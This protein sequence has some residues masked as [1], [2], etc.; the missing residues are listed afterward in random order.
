MPSGSSQLPPTMHSISTTRN[1]K[2]G[3]P[4]SQLTKRDRKRH[5][6]SHVALQQSH[7]IPATNA[8]LSCPADC[9][10]PHAIDDGI[11]NCRDQAEQS[12]A[13][14]DVCIDALAIH[15]LHTRWIDLLMA[16]E[17]HQQVQL[18]VRRALSAL[19]STVVQ[20]LN[21]CNRVEVQTN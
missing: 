2:P 11:L 3:I 6:R 1:R 14:N 21:S 5:D 8:N 10:F 7:S 17:H 4:I 18:I 9:L 16:Q 19:H 15:R 20:A 12:R 13:T